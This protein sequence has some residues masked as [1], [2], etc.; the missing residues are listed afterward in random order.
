MCSLVGGGSGASLGV[1]TSAPSVTITAPSLRL[2]R[3]VL[4]SAAAAAARRCC[5][6]RTLLLAAAA[7]PRLAA[8]AAPCRRHWSVIFI[9]VGSHQH[10]HEGVERLHGRGGE[11]GIERRY[12]EL[13][14]WHKGEL[15]NRCTTLRVHPGHWKRR[16]EH[17]QLE[18]AVQALA[19]PL[20]SPPRS[21]A[22]VLRLRCDAC[23]AAAAR[24]SHGPGTAAA[25]AC[26][27]W[28]TRRG[29][30][31]A[32]ITPSSALSRSKRLGCSTPADMH[33]D[34]GGSK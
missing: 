32:C 31:Q 34:S 28:W 20:H 17:G 16:P 11:T 25:C 9:P 21:R 2:S 33:A 30:E 7:A 1:S 24:P 15:V 4:Q 3:A 19:M 14:L 27:G 22:C 10:I 13:S 18:A 23:Q 5:R 6:R 8:A 29:D 26:T 12:I